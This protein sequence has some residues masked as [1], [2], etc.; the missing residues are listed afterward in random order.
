MDAFS[1]VWGG[2]FASIS[3]SMWTDK[4]DPSLA[5]RQ[6][7]TETVVTRVMWSEA[8]AAGFRARDQAAVNCTRPPRDAG[9]LVLAAGATGASTVKM[10]PVVEDRGSS[11][12]LFFFFF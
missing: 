11:P 7:K 5:G 4:Y 8:V 6:M 10:L 2:C 3:I 12:K 1:I 9:W